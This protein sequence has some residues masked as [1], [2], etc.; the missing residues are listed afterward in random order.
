MNDAEFLSK[1]ESIVKKYALDH[2]DKSNPD[3]NFSV[4][5]VWHCFILGNMKALLSTTLLDGMY[6]ECTYDKNKHVIY[7][8]AY[9]KIENNVFNV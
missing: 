3:V 1:A 8:D 6:Y 4:Y 5:I 7:L 2:M 9:K